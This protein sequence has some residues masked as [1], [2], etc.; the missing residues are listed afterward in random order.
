MRKQ[1]TKIVAL[2]MAL[3]L[4]MPFFTSCTEKSPLETIE[5]ALTVSAEAYAKKAGSALMENMAK[6]GSM[7]LKAEAG[8]FL[9]MI[10]ESTD[11]NFDFSASLKYYF[12][13]TH[14]KAAMSAGLTSGGV[15]IADALLCMADKSI[16][17]SSNALFGKDVYGFS[18][19]N[20]AEDFNN[21]EF[22]EDGAFPADIPKEDI[23]EMFDA[24][25]QTTAGMVVDTMKYSKEV[26]K[27]GADLKKDLYSMI[28]SYGTI[29]TVDGS[30]E[31][32]GNAHKTTD[33]SFAYTGDQLTDLIV[34]TF[35]MLRDHEA[36]VAL[37]ESF[38]DMYKAYYPHLPITVMDKELSGD[39][40]TA[41]SF[42]AELVAA[43]NA[44]L[45]EEEAMREDLKDFHFSLTV[46]ISKSTREIAGFDVYVTE[47]ENYADFRF[48]C[49]PSIT[50]IDEIGFYAKSYSAEDEELTEASVAYLVTQDDADT[51]AA[52][53][54]VVDN[55]NLSVMGVGVDLFTI[56]WDKKSG[57]YTLSVTSEEET[58]GFGGQY[59]EKKDSLIASV[60]K[61]TVRGITVNFGEI[62]LILRAEDAMPENGPYTDI[63]KMDAAELEALYIE[64]MDAIDQIASVFGE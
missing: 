9:G 10:L 45:D 8:P 13:V 49:G 40:L 63:L 1:I 30:I 21:S 3:A 53:I 22:G 46:H 25:I 48:V 44:I 28:E 54:N 20:F 19:E 23:E 14:G 39:A 31:I 36:T 37:C 52:K 56:E 64:V 59:L 43:F 29:K 51:Y 41:E 32:G 5:D 38:V 33:L 6:G 2:L 15:S 42:H 55:A 35:T 47:E 18:L 4:L 24:V 27:A 34:A 58:V 61:V 60:N 16:S 57:D 17:L 50:D 26:N 12:D 7:E 62:A 11:S